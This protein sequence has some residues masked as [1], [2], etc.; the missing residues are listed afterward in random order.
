[1]QRQLLTLA[2]LVL[3][4]L[5]A[6]AQEMFHGCGM[7][8][9]AKSS[10]V[11]E[12]NRLKN[13]FHAPGPKDFDPRVT[14]AAMLGPG[15]DENRWNSSRAGE[16]TGYVHDVKVGG[17][18]S[19]NCHA[20]DA[21]NRDTHI[22]L[23]LDPMKGGNIQRVIV[24]VT[25]R[26]REMMS[27]KGADWSTKGLRKTLLGRWVKITGWLLFDA[28][29]KQESENTAPGR[30]RNWRATAWEIHPVTGMEVVRRPIKK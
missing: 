2:I 20:R 23:V 18:E 7:E 11:Q 22:E 28:E 16:V 4:P 24:E 1:M 15:D 30:T 17:I 8:G 19:T 5:Q 3:L 12:L 21:M 14:L 27:R 29:H 26:W 9:D 6:F 25:P 13:R 10:G